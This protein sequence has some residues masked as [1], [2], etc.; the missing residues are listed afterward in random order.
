MDASSW[1]AN[2][3]AAGLLVVVATT[4]K[5]AAAEPV[6]VAI[7]AGGTLNTHADQVG[8]WI[9]STDGGLTPGLVTGLKSLGV[10]S[11]RYGWGFGRYDAVDRSGMDLVPR[12]P[13]VERYGVRD[14]RVSETLS[15]ADLDRLLAE[16]DAVGF[17]VVS[18]DGINYTGDTDADWAA[19]SPEQRLDSLATAAA[20][21]AT[22]SPGLTHFEIGNENDIAGRKDDSVI[23]P[24]TAAGYAHVVAKMI[25][26]VK[27]ARPRARCGFNG[28]LLDEAGSRVWFEQLARAEPSLADR[29]DFLVA[30][31]YEFWLTPEVW[32]EH[33]DWA[34]G[35]LPAFTRE[36]RDRHFPKLPIQVTELGAFKMGRNQAHV[37]AVLQTEML[38]NVYQDA[39]VEHVQVWPS[40]WGDEGGVLANAE[41]GELSSLG[42]G[43]A[44]YARHAQPVLCDNGS[45]GSIRYFAGRSLPGEPAAL[46]V[47]LVNHAASAVDVALTIETAA[48]GLPAST[49][50]CVA[51]VEEGGQTRLAAQPAAT[52]GGGPLPVTVPGTA[53][54]VL[55][56]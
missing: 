8:V 22:Q 51:L 26:T 23:K 36:A 44:A 16:L 11:I 56:W 6:A 20:D 30:H 48:D 47:W 3:W 37:R 14:G 5:A 33:A 35:R 34:F 9:N 38:G 42:L 19:L 25:D 53:V 28:G 55:R 32:A 43:M 46:T 52:R 50:A 29:A 1:A 39:A 15:P 12:D 49:T 45:A 54:L 7:D 27:A 18:T 2:L 31:K 21:W 4:V 10:R 17:G 13:R 40:T 24:W 41:T